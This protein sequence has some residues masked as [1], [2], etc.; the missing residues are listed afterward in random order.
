MELLN[1]VCRMHL[2]QKFLIREIKQRTAL[3][4]NMVT[5]H[6]AANTIESI[7]AKP[8]RTSK[9]DPVAE[10]LGAWLMIDAWKSRKQRRTLKQLHADFV[11]L[12]SERVKR[13]MAHIKLAPSQAFLLCACPLQTY[14]TLYD[15]L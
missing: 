6:L 13:Q 7:F 9:H 10:K 3:S 4:R 11:V 2:R 8:E 1:I 14:E 12:G 15:A 5:R